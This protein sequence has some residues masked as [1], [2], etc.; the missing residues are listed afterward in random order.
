MS[1]FF[2]QVGNIGQTLGQTFG[3]TL[4]S[5]LG[6][7]IQ[8]VQQVAAA[9]EEL[10]VGSHTVVVKE[11]LAEGRLLCNIKKQTLILCYSSQIS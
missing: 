8:H 7:G 9:P 1:S 6:Q 11:H 10:R 5:T 4:Q 2:N 3:Q